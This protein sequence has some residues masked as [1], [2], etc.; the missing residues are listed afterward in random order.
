MAIFIPGPRAPSL[1]TMREAAVVRF[2]A[3]MRGTPGADENAVARAW[4]AITDAAV[5]EFA[6]D[7]ATLLA[8]LAG[9]PELL[10]AGTGLG[11]EPDSTLRDD[12]RTALVGAIY[13][14]LEAEFFDRWPAR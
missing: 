1:G 8:V 9:A 11:A 4:E 10:D 2:S 12:V 7:D 3:W 14:A 6:P 5:A 13:E